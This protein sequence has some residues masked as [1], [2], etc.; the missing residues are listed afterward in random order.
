MATKDLEQFLRQI[1]AGRA[2]S[3]DVEGAKVEWI[4]GIK[5]LYKRISGW[6]EP[7]RKQGLVTVTPTE[8]T[9]REESLGV[10]SAPGLEIAAGGRKVV[11]EPIARVVFG[12][13]GRVDMGHGPHSRVLIREL[14]ETEKW[15]VSARSPNDGGRELTEETFSDALQ[16]LL[17]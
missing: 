12:G 11:L 15:I 8:L 10:Y 2:P 1:Q 13:S 17:S 3:L 5:K 14:T 7:L 6:L 16:A 4:D 9:I